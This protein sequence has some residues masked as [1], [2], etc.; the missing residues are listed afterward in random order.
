M[1]TFFSKNLA[2]FA[3]ILA[4]SCAYAADV[5]PTRPTAE[6]ADRI[7]LRIANAA[8]LKIH[9]LVAGSDGDGVALIGEDPKTAVTVRKGSVISRNLD[10]IKV[11]VKIRS[12]SPKGVEIEA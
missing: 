9:A 1:K 10:S 5:D 8:S 2:V 7:K 11:D 3:L 6:M 4:I 12:V